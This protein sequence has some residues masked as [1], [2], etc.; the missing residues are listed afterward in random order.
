MRHVAAADTGRHMLSTCAQECA[1]R[2]TSK[3]ETKWKYL[4][5][6]V[7][8]HVNALNSMVMSSVI[9]NQNFVTYITFP[10]T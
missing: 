9:S 4:I 2:E 6:D 1:R 8:L 7:K 5:I 10:L 3:N